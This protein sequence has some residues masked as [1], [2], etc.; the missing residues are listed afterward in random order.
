[1]ATRWVE[2]VPGPVGGQATGAPR[3]ERQLQIHWLAEE[4]PSNPN[5]YGR[6]S[7]ARNDLNKCS[8][9]PE[10]VVRLSARRESELAALALGR[11]SAKGRF[12][13]RG[14]SPHAR[15][16][17]TE[18]FTNREFGLEDGVLAKERTDDADDAGLEA[19]RR[20]D[21]GIG[22]WAECDCPSSARTCSGS[23]EGRID[24]QVQEFVEKVVEGEKRRAR[25]T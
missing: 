16:S 23:T 17:K 22:E 24:R 4:I 1:M 3:E 19:F 5:R 18:E 2:T 6:T 7:K 20:E 8:Q 13:Q 11:R 14:V 12:P 10:D 9:G 25:E 15:S 21:L